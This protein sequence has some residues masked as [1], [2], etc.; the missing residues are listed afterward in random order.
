MG[1]VMDI[2]PCRLPG[3][4]SPCRR[5]NPI[6]RPGETGQGAGH[7]KQGQGH[8]VEAPQPG[9]GAI[10][11]PAGRGFDADQGVVLLVLV[12]VDGVVP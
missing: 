11:A 9:P 12:G 6:E 2:D 8:R 7:G 10:A 3:E 5:Q 4:M 1:R